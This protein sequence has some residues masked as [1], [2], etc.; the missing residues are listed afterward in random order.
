MALNRASPPAA[1][2]QRS[3][4]RDRAPAWCVLAL[5]IA[6]AP[7]VYWPRVLTHDHPTDLK[8]P[9]AAWGLALVVIVSLLHRGQRGAPRKP[10]A[11]SLLLIAGLLIALGLA[12]SSWFSPARS[13]G[14]R[15]GLREVM[16]VAVACRLSF[17]RASP[18]HVLLIF[19][20]LVASAS[21]QATLTFLQY[22][23]M[24]GGE[25]S[26]GR[27]SMLGTLGNP[28]YVASWM[29]PAVAVSIVWL[30][31]RSLPLPGKLG[32]ILGAGLIGGSIILS[33]GR[34]AA[35]GIVA[36]LITVALATRLGRVRRIEKSEGAEEAE[37]PTEG[38]DEEEGEESSEDIGGARR[39]ARRGASLF[40]R[41]PM[42]A[43]L[44]LLIVVGAIA[45][46]NVGGTVRRQSLVGRLAEMFDPYST[47]VRHRIGLVIV[48]SKMIVDRPI[49]GAGPG[50][51]GAAFDRTR[52][53]MA[54]ED[55]SLGQ[56][57]FN[58]F[59]S[60][61]SATEAHC[62]PLQWWA[63][64][65]LLPFAGLMLVIASTLATLIARS[66]TDEDSRVAV[67]LLAAFVT[68]A[69]GMFFSFPL[70]R[71]ARAVLFWAL[72]GLAHADGRG[73]SSS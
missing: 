54:R 52:G 21:M 51:F 53:R 1:P 39:G 17:L 43:A 68:I 7:W 31:R 42:F 26:G 27:G 57:A 50:R 46:L 19:G 22:R 34:G 12:L 66:R 49:W 4:G 36:A 48:T 61:R 32:L 47:S 67:L 24:F 5:L 60:D 23:G 15:V 14:F 25:T 40:A 44:G 13:L 55:R 56:W 9:V 59:L 29:A 72:V 30:G 35:L 71:P 28:E 33:G 70:H 38:E 65:G 45:A 69:V 62:D 20:L 58:D 18:K 10:A 6:L 64:Y 11:R 41:W 2:K 8:W 3:H 63:E 73:E 37:R 16:F